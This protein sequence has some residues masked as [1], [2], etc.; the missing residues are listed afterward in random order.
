DGQLP[1]DI[2]WRALA[3]PLATTVV[4]MALG[5]LPLLA[6]RLLEAG[7]RAET[8]AIALYNVG[9]GD[10]RVV[11]GTIASLSAD[12]AASGGAG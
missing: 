11:R 10:E 9:L 1:S 5:S 7:V 12:V 3:D 2:D 8:Q 6:A 4:F